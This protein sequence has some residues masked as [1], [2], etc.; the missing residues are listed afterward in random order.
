MTVEQL[1]RTSPLARV[2]SRFAGLPDGVELAEEAF[3]AQAGLR[4]APGGPA[5]AH[6]AERLGV[7]LPG[8]ARWVRGTTATVVWLGPDEW[9]V[10]D[11]AVAPADL[12]ALLRA[13]VG[14]GAGAVVDVSAQRTTLRL[15][16]AH[17]RD[18]LATG[19][20]IDLHPRVFAAGSA[21]QTV[22]GQAGVILLALDEHGT[23]YR[24]LIRASFAGY[25]AAWLLDAATEFSTD[26]GA[27][28]ADDSR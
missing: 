25:L 27:A 11:P 8:P 18:L 15:R 2:S 9:L 20:A 10:T 21:A 23:D 3:V 5:A 16:G 17:A 14:P 24:I 19:C 6:V 22:L 7:A 26:P 12:E 13:A 28:R 1:A 4:V